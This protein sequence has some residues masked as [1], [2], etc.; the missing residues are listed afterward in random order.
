V[1]LKTKARPATST[2]SETSSG[3][4]KPAGTPR[5]K[6]MTV[7]TQTVS[8]ISEAKKRASFVKGELQRTGE[9]IEQYLTRIAS[10]RIL[11]AAKKQ[12]KKVVR[13][14]E[15]ERKPVLDLTAVSSTLR[16]AVRLLN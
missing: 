6:T 1:L 9:T 2:V 15:D 13:V 14:L 8:S 4:L 7:S 10:E 12:I 3:W 5:K 11:A 16:E